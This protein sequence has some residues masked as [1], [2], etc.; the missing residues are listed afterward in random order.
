MLNRVMEA[1]QEFD[2]ASARIDA[3]QTQQSQAVSAQGGQF[4][5]IGRTI[6][7]LHGQ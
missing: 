7:R 2:L 1:A 6:I 5:L 3:L 4:S